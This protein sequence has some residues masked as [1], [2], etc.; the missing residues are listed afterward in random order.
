MR[1]A[2]WSW[3]MSRPSSW[4]TFR[5]QPDAVPTETFP[6]ERQLAAVCHIEGVGSVEAGYRATACLRQ[7]AAGRDRRQA[8]QGV[9]LW[10]APDGW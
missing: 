9:W 8:R 10:V 3:S 5:A 1:T 6:R 7:P 2:P 4:E